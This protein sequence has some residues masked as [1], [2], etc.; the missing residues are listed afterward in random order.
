MGGHGRPYGLVPNEEWRA[1]I[2][3]KALE[4]TSP[5]V[6]IACIDVAVHVQES[7]VLVQLPQFN[8]ALVLR[9]AG[10]PLLF[11]FLLLLLLG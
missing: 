9:Q 6:S 2:T 7:Y 5:G 1:I 4:L 10:N 11:G 3:D 8:L